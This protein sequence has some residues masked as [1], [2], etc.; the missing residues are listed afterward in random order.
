MTTGVTI[1][2][3]ANLT[4]FTS[5]VDK[6]TS[7][8]SKFQSNAERMGKNLQGVFGALG[9][10]VSLGALAANIK[11]VVNNADEMGKLAQKTGTAVDALS[12]LDYAAKLANVS[13]EQ[14]ATGLEKLSKNLLAAQ[15]GSTEAAQAF[16]LIGLDP[17]Q[18]S[19]AD[20]ALKAV[21]EKFANMPDGVNKTAAAI[22][23]FGKSGAELVPLLNAGASG[24]KE[25]ADEAEKLG[26][27][28]SSKM[29]ADS[30][31]FNDNMTRLSET[32]RGLWIQLVGN[33]GLL[34][35][36][37]EIAQ[38]MVDTAKKSGVLA[39]AFVGLGEAFKAA[40]FGTRG[41]ELKQQQ[42][43][44]GGL[45]QEIK[46]LESNLEYFKREHRDGI[47][48]DLMHGGNLEKNKRELAALKI[49]LADAK[50]ALGTMQIKEE[51]RANPAAKT[52]GLKI[53]PQAI[54]G[55]ADKTRSFEDYSA[56]INAAVAGAINNSDIVKAQ[57]YADTVARLDSLFF[58]AGLSAEVY[59]S[60]LKKLSGSTEGTNAEFEK[61][62]ARLDGLLSGTPIQKTAELQSNLEF[63][64]QAFFDGAI[65]AEQWQQAVDKLTGKF[66]DLGDN[67]KKTKSFSEE[68]GLTF[69]SAMEDAIVSGKKFSEVLKSIG[70]D[71]LKIVVRKNFT[72][73]LGNAVS[74]ID[75]GQII[76]SLFG[77]FKAGGGAVYGGKAYIVGERGPEL[78]TPGSA[79]AI[80]P[81]A[82][83]GGGVTINVIESP[84]SGGQVSRRTDEG[85]Q[86]VIDIMVERVKASIAGDISRGAGPV[87]GALANTYGLNRV[88][89][90]Y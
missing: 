59:E 24:L 77:G 43:F 36:L 86:S 21:A 13:R 26:I 29:A 30:E 58:D 84:G 54:G 4:R 45:E 44:V 56:K 20:E 51:L 47:L 61:F 1:D 78:F 52:G 40:I 88:A 55:A 17:K 90:A 32:S 53:P 48:G 28:I 16:Q 6:A 49:T 5:A 22:K 66:N 18:F 38:S 62:Q 46:K 25:M 80:T 87:P 57:E 27:V 83:L 65:S 2:F 33:S 14:L 23:L 42:E 39:A 81:N 64:D 60:A 89:G 12:K 35:A 72:E 74:G 85:G 8:L 41:S 11:S 76:G 34:D 7:D 68:F 37:N 9:V 70:Q 50:I 10:G 79:G 15:T 19:S 31:R 71:I 82:A 73:P 3:N 67:I 63:L 75:F 69:S